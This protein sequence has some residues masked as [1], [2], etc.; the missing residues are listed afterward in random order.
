MFAGLGGGNGLFGMKMNR[1][2]HVHRVDARVGDELAPVRIP[3]PGAD[4]TRKRLDEIGARAADGGELAPGATPQR[5]SHALPNDVTGANQT[6]TEA[7][8]L[9]LASC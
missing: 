5:L 6:P 1:R 8:V 4:L 3:S 2:R 7:T 9:R